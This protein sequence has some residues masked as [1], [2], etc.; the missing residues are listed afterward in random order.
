MGYMYYKAQYYPASVA[1]FSSK[2]DSSRNQ[3]LLFP[4]PCLRSRF[5]FSPGVAAVTIALGE[6]HTCAIVSGGGVK[7]WGNNGNGQLGI[8]NRTDATRP[9]DVA[10]D[11]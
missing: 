10:G 8:G 2:G 7:C 1:I 11:G 9:A 4:S 3:L 6:S 5:L